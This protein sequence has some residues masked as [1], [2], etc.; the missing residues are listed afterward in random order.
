M[1]LDRYMTRGHTQV[2]DL[3]DR[4]V[5]KSGE[6]T[7]TNQDRTSKIASEVGRAGLEPATNGFG[8]GSSRHVSQ[9]V[10][11]QCRNRFRNPFDSQ[12]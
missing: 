1:T 5:A 3:L 7:V 6:Q 4:T 10:I 11:S 12:R 8:F 9:P 2:A